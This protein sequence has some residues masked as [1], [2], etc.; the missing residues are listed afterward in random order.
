MKNIVFLVIVFFTS[1]SPTHAQFSINKMVGKNASN[2]RFGYGLFAFYDFY[3]GGSENRSVRLELLDF[4][5]FPLDDGEPRFVTPNGRAF[6]S[7]R[8][9]YKHILSETKTGFYLLPTV[10]YCRSIITEYPDIAR[11]RDGIALA[12]ES[13]YS[14]EVGQR[15]NSFNFGLKYENDRAVTEHTIGSVGFRVSYSFNFFRRK[16]DF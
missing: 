3:L 12:M 1:F 16:D 10:G 9:G 6:L 7:I 11:N 2:H 4:V 13:G 5:V 14:L 8:L 15:G